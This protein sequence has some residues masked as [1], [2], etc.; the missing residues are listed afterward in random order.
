MPAIEGSS[1]ISG[2]FSFNYAE[3]KWLNECTHCGFE[4]LLYESSAEY[5]CPIC[6]QGT[7]NRK[8]QSTEWPIT[9]NIFHPSP[10][11][12]TGQELTEGIQIAEV[13]HAL[14]DG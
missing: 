12:W 9:T 13:D 7:M 3:I 11:G 10:T 6:R 2:D 8:E 4:A 5:E 1:T 14:D